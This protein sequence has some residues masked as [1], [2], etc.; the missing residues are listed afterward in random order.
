MIILQEDFRF[1]REEYLDLLIE[2]LENL[3]PE[4]VIHRITGER[5]KRSSDRSFVGIEKTGGSESASP[6]DER[7]EQLPG[8]KFES[9]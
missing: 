2:C 1:M 8:K 5:A 7:T 9:F 6:S 3:D 4:I